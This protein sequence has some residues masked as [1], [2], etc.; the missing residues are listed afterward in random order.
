MPEQDLR[1]EQRVDQPAAPEATISTYHPNY[2]EEIIRTL[3]GFSPYEIPHQSREKTAM[4]LIGLASNFASPR[5]IAPMVA[6]LTKQQILSGISRPAVRESVGQ[7]LEKIPQA[8]LDKLKGFREV[9][10][11][12]IYEAAGLEHKPLEAVK[13]TYRP[14][15]R[16]IFIA[17]PKEVK[18]KLADKIYN[19]FLETGDSDLIRTIK[20]EFAH[21]FEEFMTSNDALKAVGRMKEL[22]VR[23]KYD[24]LL[25]G[26]FKPKASK[27]HRELFAETLQELSPGET[28][29][30]LQDLFEKV[31][32]RKLVERTGIR[33]EVLKSVTE[34]P[35]AGQFV[36][37]LD[38]AGNVQKGK[39]RDYDSYS[40][41]AM[42]FPQDR[43]LIPKDPISQAR[44]S[45][46]VPLD[47]ITKL[48]GGPR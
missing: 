24:K 9:A 6:A 11:K 38:E 47:R 26:L 20:H 14:A 40:K 16:D 23:A 18:N 29:Y 31:A 30:V 13:G 3:V 27:E 17:V 8:I 22:G 43:S 45:I 37:F 10:P 42:I 15:E 25:E 19:W 34:E 21:H 46:D 36:I 5:T 32:K 35:R 39:I 4:D 2:L 12:E 28:G 41:T 44:A 48:E 1:W 33:T 7:Y